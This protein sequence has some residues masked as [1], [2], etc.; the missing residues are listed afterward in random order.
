MA[1]LN[2]AIKTTA[3]AKDRLNEKWVARR[4]VINKLFAYC[5]SIMQRWRGLS[6]FCL[7]ARNEYTTRVRN[8]IITLKRGNVIIDA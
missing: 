7:P 2:S 4:G 6:G 8:V 3:D 1:I 5:A